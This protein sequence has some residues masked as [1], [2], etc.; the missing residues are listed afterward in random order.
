MA[1]NP[2]RLKPT[3]RSALA[4]NAGTIFGAL[5]FGA[6]LVVAGVYQFEHGYYLQSAGAAVLLGL[7]VYSAFTSLRDSLLGRVLPARRQ[8]AGW[9]SLRSPAV[10]ALLVVTVAFTCAGWIAPHH[11][12]LEQGT[13]GRT[14]VWGHREWWRLLTSMFLHANTTHLY[15]NMA[16]LWVLGLIIDSTLGTPRFLAVYVA[17]GIGGGLMVV[18]L[19]QERT[20]GSSGAI[21][22]LMGAVLYFGCHALKA[23][24][25]S[26]AK[27]MLMASATLVGFNLLLSFAIPIISIAAHVGGLIAGFVVAALVGFPRKLNDAWA[28]SDR[29]PHG[30]SVTYDVNTDRFSYHGPVA[31]ALEKGLVQPNEGAR[32]K[33]AGWAPFVDAADLDPRTPIDCYVDEPERLLNESTPG[34]APAAGAAVSFANTPAS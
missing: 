33:T 18:A 25:R 15:F 3:F 14:G 11:W 7:I 21:Y 4:D 6:I 27:R 31:F 5:F 9:S 29:C 19:G 10:I 2:S 8:I 32:T 13:V 12:Y 26:A 20:L 22:G 34:G 23:G 30:A 16:A 1:R 17:A 28:M 24:H